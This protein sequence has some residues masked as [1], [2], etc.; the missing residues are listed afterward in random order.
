M[1]F[2]EEIRAAGDEFVQKALG[3]RGY[4][5]A[6]CRRTDFLRVRT[7]TTPGPE[8]IAA[9]LNAA[10][11][12][13][14]LSQVFVATDAP[15]E[16]RE[17]LQRLVKGQVRFYDAASDAKSFEH[18]G[19]QA[20][21][22][23]WVAARADFFVGTQESRFTMSIQL[24]RGFLGKPKHT[25]EQEFCKTFDDS[26]EAKPCVAPNYRQPARPGAHQGAIAR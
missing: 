24:E 4:V 22:E 7:K 19:K 16:L 8:A 10:L 1:L 23:V 11:A 21:V 20:A 14:G 3:G 2:S 25:S 13:S 18:P 5:A 17:E 9:K 15:S 26:G 6:H 12:E